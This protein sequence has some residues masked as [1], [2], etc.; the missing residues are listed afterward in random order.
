MHWQV[1]EG[2]RG[3]ALKGVLRF[4][5][6]LPEG[7]CRVGAFYKLAGVFRIFNVKEVIVLAA[8]VP[9]KVSI[10]VRK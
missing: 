3:Y 9:A 7:N 10:D 1:G 8:K 4:L 5:S 6:A 2:S